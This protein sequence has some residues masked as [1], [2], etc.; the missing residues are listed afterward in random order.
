MKTDLDLRDGVV[1]FAK[2]ECETCQMVEPV[3][4]QLAKSLPTVIL[5]Q[6]DPTFPSIIGLDASRARLDELI[7]T[8]LNAIAPFQERGALLSELARYAANRMR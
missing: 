6:D 1:V 7:N 8:A 2:R 5:T 4:G 3:L